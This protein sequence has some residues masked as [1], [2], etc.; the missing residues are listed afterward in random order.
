MHDGWLGT[1][2]RFILWDY[3]RGSLQ[4]DIMCA[5]ILAFIF[6]TPA[7]VFRDQPK[8]QSVVMLPGEAGAT[9]FWIEPEL[10]DGYPEE[11]R[12]V[13]V[14]SLIKSHAKGKRF[15]LTRVEPIFDSEEE[16]KGYMAFA[17]AAK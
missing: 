13:R 9:V 8:A 4:Y 11:D 2:K 3:S 6:L 10:L 15:D 16:V 5:I 1:L 14:Q 17:S 12:N 7:A